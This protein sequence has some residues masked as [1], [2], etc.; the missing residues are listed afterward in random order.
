[1]NYDVIVIGAGASGLFAAG[2]IASEGLSVCLFEKK[3]DR[4]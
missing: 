2:K 3:Q 1:M 4:Q